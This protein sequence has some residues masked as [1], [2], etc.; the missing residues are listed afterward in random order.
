MVSYRSTP[1]RKT[2]DGVCLDRRASI[3]RLRQA[4]IVSSNSDLANSISPPAV[5]FTADGAAA[6]GNPFS[7]VPAERRTSNTHTACRFSLTV[8]ILI[9]QQQPHRRRHEP[10]N[11]QRQVRVSRRHRIRS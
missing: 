2:H 7:L 11:H 8:L 10:F 1:I 3:D 5:R 4:S 9:L 6:T